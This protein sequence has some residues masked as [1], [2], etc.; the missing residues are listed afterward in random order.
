MTNR[1][2]QSSQ[3]NNQEI[4]SKYF[5]DVQPNYVL[6]VEPLETGDERY[7]PLSID[8]E[9]LMNLLQIY[10]LAPHFITFKKLAIV[11]PVRIA[12]WNHLQ[13]IK[14]S[15]DEAHNQEHDLIH[16]AWKLKTGNVSWIEIQCNSGDKVKLSQLAFIQDLGKAIMKEF[17][18]TNITK[19]DDLAKIE[20]S[21]RK[22]GKPLKMLPIQRLI[23]SILIYLER[24]TDLKCGDYLITNK[25]ANFIS[26]FLHFAKVIEPDSTKVLDEE[27]IRTSLNNYRTKYPEFFMSLFPRHL[28]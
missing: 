17:G 3:A 6:V 14:K 13:N 8:E 20:K 21:I 2:H 28:K 9:E 22:K 12:E 7:L 27:Y 18:F 26:D 4:F 11:A 1:K 19:E 23:L 16:L 5:S 10:G 15:L 24:E 25:Q